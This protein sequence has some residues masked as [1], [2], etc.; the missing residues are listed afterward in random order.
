[1]RF[2]NRFDDGQPQPGPAA[3]LL[4]RDIG[5][6]RA[7]E[8]V[9]Q[10]LWGDPGA[11]VCHHQ[12]HLGRSGARQQ[13]HLSAGIRVTQRIADQVAQRA[14][15]V[16][17]VNAD[18]RQALVDADVQHDALLFGRVLVGVGDPSEQRLRR[19]ELP[20]EVQLARVGQGE[21]VQVLHEM[22]Q[23]LNFVVHH[24]EALGRRLEHLV[25]QGLHVTGNDCQRRAQ[26][27]GDIGCHLAAQLGGAR[28]VGTHMVELVREHPQLI[29]RAHGHALLQVAGGDFAGSGR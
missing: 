22:P 21:R 14:D 19:D 7:L 25:A 2:D 10:M 16:L 11:G 12:L 23:Q 6:V 3:L 15:H 20:V 18:V 1:M 8:N 5:T 13:R 24:G 9:G 4:A 26:I 29:A 17:R 27:V 28:Q